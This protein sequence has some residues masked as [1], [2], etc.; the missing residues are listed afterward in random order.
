LGRLRIDRLLADIVLG[1][2]DDAVDHEVGLL[3]YGLELTEAVDEFSR[4][5]G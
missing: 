2:L 3:D 4:V 5:S 1:D